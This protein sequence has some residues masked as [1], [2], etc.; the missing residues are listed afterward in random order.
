MSDM[1]A[2]L[3]NGLYYTRI[4]SHIGA[5]ECPRQTDGTDAMFK[6]NGTQDTGARHCACV[7]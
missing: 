2:L 4:Q 1:A 3:L 7:T 5:I 6:Y